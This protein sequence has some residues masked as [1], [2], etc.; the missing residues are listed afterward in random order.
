ML[1]GPTLPYNFGRRKGRHSVRSTLTL[2]PGLLVD[3]AHSFDFLVQGRRA[4]RNVYRLEREELNVE[5]RFTTLLAA[6]FNGLRF[7][8]A[9]DFLDV[10]TAAPFQSYKREQF[11]LTFSGRI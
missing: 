3:A 6:V 4:L 7:I 5:T 1:L 2:P 10:V 9:E 11:R 8:V